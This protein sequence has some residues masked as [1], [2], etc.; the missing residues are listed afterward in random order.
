[1]PIKAEKVRLIKGINLQIIANTVAMA[2][3]ANGP[4]RAT[5]ASPYFL[6]LKR[7]GLYGTG[8]AQANKNEDPE[9]SIIS[10]TKSDPKTSICLIGLKVNLPAS[11]A[12]VS[13]NLKAAKACMYS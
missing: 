13:P 5:L 10:G 12:V 8:L 7:L 2:R 3:F 4:A 1:M 9:K 6:S 11:L